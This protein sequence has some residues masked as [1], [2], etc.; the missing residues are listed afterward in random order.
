MRR[1]WLLVVLVSAA[2]I[3]CRP[4]A[5]SSPSVVAAAAPSA[6]VSASGGP[7]VEPS[8]A[9]PLLPPA[10]A[11]PLDRE[12]FA[13]AEAEVPAVERDLEQLVNID[14]GTGDAGG[15]AK[16]GALLAA[17][18]SELGA[19]VDTTSA[20]PSAGSTITASLHG[21]GTR[22]VL[23]MIHFD[24]VFAPGE[25][26]R[27]PFRR[28]GTRVFGPGVADAK[29]GAAILLHALAIAKRRG[30][31]GYRTLSVLFNP[32][33]EKGSIG[34]RDAIGRLASSQDY[35][36]SYEPPDGERVIVATNG[37]GQ[38]ELTVKGR[39][40]HA[41]A[42]PE[43]GRNAA[44]ELAHQVLQL[45][46]LGE[47]A[48][49]TTVNWTVLASGERTNIIPDLAR[50]TADLRYSDPSE[51]GRVEHD[52]QQLSR[53]HLV[54]DTQVSV[55]VIDRRPPFTKNPA[56]ERLAALAARVYLGLGRELG[57]VAARYGTDAGY[58][59]RAA[60]A[61]PAVLEGL[62]I[63]GGGLHTPDEWADTGSIAPRLY[64][65][66]KLIE[67]LGNAP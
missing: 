49:G 57:T 48:K 60:Q 1:Q 4:G 6:N 55:A 61:R 32:D 24:T 38:V 62:G 40:A 37:I 21:S 5:A 65:T 41:G 53:E 39:S 45:D 67:L 12:L 54:P 36:L 50:A 18:L 56:S 16:V 13:A 43:Q 26:G 42:A 14:S 11:V 52:A 22:D 47:P 66:L 8:A 27:R 15:L 58:A 51:L 64:L 31:T 34:S 63:V 7:S 30:I 3:S 10:N 44:L 2:A 46:H 35:V 29:G 59:Y 9:A 23:L 25:A 33:E 19:R 17:R 20:A 28:E